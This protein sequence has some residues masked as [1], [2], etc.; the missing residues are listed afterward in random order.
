MNNSKKVR[1]VLEG[2]SLSNDQIDL[3][4]GSIDEIQEKMTAQTN[5]KLEDYVVTSQLTDM[6][7]EFAQLSEKLVKA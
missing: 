2:T 1:N 3:I 4:M 7:T 6:Q 5:T